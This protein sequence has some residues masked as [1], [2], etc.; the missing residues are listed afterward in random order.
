MKTP[1]LLKAAK[2]ADWMQV[3]GNGG[4]P[5]FHLE[6]N[7]FFVV[8]LPVMP[9]TQVEEHHAMKTILLIIMPCVLAAT[10]FVVLRLCFRRECPPLVIRHRDRAI[11]ECDANDFLWRVEYIPRRWWRF[12]G[13]FERT[14]MK[15]Y[16]Q[17][18]KEYDEVARE[19]VEAG[20]RKLHEQ[21][22]RNRHDGR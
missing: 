1:K 12:R 22:Q 18:E 14:G 9:H 2:D 13:R 16:P 21:Q 19:Y 17:S 6:G 7:R 3:V 15:W 4:P 8:V 10:S 20:A 11:F 5:C